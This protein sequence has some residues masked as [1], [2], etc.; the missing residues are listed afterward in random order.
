MSLR[1]LA[2]FPTIRY[3]YFIVEK[4]SGFKLRG[5]SLHT[6]EK[7][8]EPLTANEMKMPFT[9]EEFA[10][11]FR[12]YNQAIFPLQ[13]VFYLIA[14]VAI[15][16]AIRK[17]RI[18]S[19]AVMLILSFFWVWMGLF[20]HIT[21]FSTVNKVATVFGA[22]FILQ[23]V[24]FAYYSNKLEFRFPSD[25]YGLIGSLLILFSLAVY[26][27]IGYFLGHVYPNAPTFGVPCPTTIFTFGVLLLTDKK[28]PLL[29][30]IIPGLWTVIGLSAGINL[31]FYEDFGLVIS[32]GLAI[33][34]LAARWRFL[35]FVNVENR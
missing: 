33:S 16:Y 3:T 29:L 19:I 11:V 5:F 9:P 27:S 2:Q 31:G 7:K 6:I 8:I 10:E 26:P 35:Q 24:L 18:S 1:T 20:Y 30:L 14:L 32:G 17:T 13:G 25:K 23:G 4:P 28:C 21:Y 34:L 12:N 22:F 15:F